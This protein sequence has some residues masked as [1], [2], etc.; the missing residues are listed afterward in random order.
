MLSAIAADHVQRPR[1]AGP[2]EGATHVGRAGVPGDGPYCVLHLIVRE[3]VIFKATYQTNGCPSSIAA[4]SFLCQ[5][6]AGR[7]VSRVLTLTDSE[8]ILAIGG[9]PDGKGDCATRAIA[10]L[11]DAFHTNG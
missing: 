5:L 9:L 8:L 11:K 1:N 4:A 7:E 10:A 2:L 6:A 3:G